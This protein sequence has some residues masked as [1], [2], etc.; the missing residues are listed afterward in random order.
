MGSIG[1]KTLAEYLNDLRLSGT[2]IRIWIKGV[3]DE[4]ECEFIKIHK[5]VTDSTGNVV[6]VMHYGFDGG[7]DDSYIS[8]QKWEEIDSFAISDTDQEGYEED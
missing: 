2:V 6:G 3:N 5:V 1:I 7:S 8:Y 4:D